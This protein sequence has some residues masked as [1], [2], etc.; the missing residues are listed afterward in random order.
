[1]KLLRRQIKP[2]L[3]RI[4]THA[5]RSRRGTGNHQIFGSSF[6]P[7][8]H[9]WLVG[10][11]ADDTKR[12][13]DIDLYIQTHLSGENAYIKRREFVIDLWD[14]I[15]EQKI[16]IV[17]HLVDTDFHLPIYDVAQKERVQLA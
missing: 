15:G 8:D 9:L 13:G 16:D 14:K 7:D 6:G 3:T 11:R 4:D 5:F 2:S 17:V 12:G 1:M 10:S